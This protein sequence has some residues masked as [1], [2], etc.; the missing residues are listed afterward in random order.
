MIWRPGIVGSSETENEKKKKN[1][2]PFFS[3][4]FF[5]SSQTHFHILTYNIHAVFYY[6]IHFF[7]AYYTKI[8]FV[9]KTHASVLPTRNTTSCKKSR[10]RTANVSL[11]PLPARSE[12]ELA[13]KKINFMVNND[14]LRIT[15]YVKDSA[16]NF[17]PLK[18]IGNRWTVPQTQ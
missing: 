10:T 5:F 6:F 15:T 16:V 17:F 11:L 2:N 3:F 9:W 13:T 14:N 4:F 7:R 8:S 12:P 1:E 18:L